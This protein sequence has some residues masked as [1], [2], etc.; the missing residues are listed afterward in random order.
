MKKII[1]NIVDRM[2]LDGTIEAEDKEIY[3]YGLTQGIIMIFN[4]VVTLLIG[5]MLH[6]FWETFIFLAVYMPLRS[7]AGGIHAKTQLRCFFYSFG[8]VFLILGIIYYFPNGLLCN[9]ILLLFSDVVICLFSP[10]ESENKP[11]DEEEIFRYGKKA[12]QILL[13]YN[14]VT[15]ITMILKYRLIYT[16]VSVTLATV[17]VTVLLGYRYNKKRMKL[18]RSEEG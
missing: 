8:I 5:L 17:S 14:A 3:E 11:L 15:V 2:I 6:M 10:V 9:C 16:S 4:I 13:F 18:T 12:K 1:S 7:Y